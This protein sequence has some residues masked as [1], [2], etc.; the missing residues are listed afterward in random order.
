MTHACDRCHEDT[1][2]ED[3]V[4]VD[5]EFWCIECVKLGQYGYWKVEDVVLAHMTGAI[6]GANRLRLG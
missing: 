6:S 4:E 3:L 2:E 5:D 1:E